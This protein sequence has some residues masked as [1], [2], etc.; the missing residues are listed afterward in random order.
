MLNRRKF[1]AAGTAAGVGAAGLT[2]GA[3]TTQPQPGQLT[4][5]SLANVLLAMGLKP[6][7]EQKRF[8]F[9]FKAVFAGEE[10]VLSMS[11]VLSQ[12]AESVWVMAWL[13]ELPRAASEVPRTALLRL[14]AL[15]DRMGNGKFFAYI[16]ANRRFVLQRVVPNV[17]MSTANFRGVLQDLGGSVVES[18][19]HW[20]VANWTSQPSNSAS[21]PTRSTAAAPQS[22]N[23]Q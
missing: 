16:A 20:S 9:Q 15:N 8:D 6:T 1:L 14:L 18:Y 3:Q 2:A 12:N 5:Q 13:D 4:E 22:T 10:W 21:R 11:A 23:R 17:N 7:K 19:A